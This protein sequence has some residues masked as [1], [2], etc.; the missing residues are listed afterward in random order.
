MENRTLG[1]QEE[2]GRNH[3]FSLRMSHDSV[4]E[5][6]AEEEYI[7]CKCERGKFVALPN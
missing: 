5:L 2:E 4:L 6:A 3:S 7:K 1:V